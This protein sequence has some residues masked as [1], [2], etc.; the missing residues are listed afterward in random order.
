MVSPSDAD[1]DLMYRVKRGGP[2]AHEALEALVNRWR[3]PV[4]NFIFRSLPDAGEAEDLANVVFFQLWKTAARYQASARFSTFLFTIARNLCLN[5][6]RRR[7]RHPAESLDEPHP[8][9]EGHPY[10]Q[11]SSP[12]EVSADVQLQ[13]DELVA[14]VDEAL[15]Q[16]PEKQR[17]AL[18]LC[19]DTDLSYDEI[20]EILGTSVQATKSLIHRAREIL[21]SRLKP[22]LKTGQWQ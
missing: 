20:A 14:K 16:L 17:T 12:D 4:L 9:D 11:I 7:G 1:A 21:K 19:R 18:L 13:R 15:S 22:Y 6:I 10:R 3:Q 2:D 5:E 8:D